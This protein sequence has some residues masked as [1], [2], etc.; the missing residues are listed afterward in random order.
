[1]ELVQEQ[2]FGQVACIFT[3]V[4]VSNSQQGIFA[5]IT[6]QHFG[7]VRLQKIVKPSGTRSFPGAHVQ[8]P[9]Q[10]MN[11]LKNSCGFRFECGF[12][13][14]ISTRIPNRRR[15]R[16]LMPVHPNILGVIHEGAPCT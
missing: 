8:T 9:A 1:M 6:N 12:H 10:T 15:D 13:H 3:V 11:K 14:Q 5:R 16:C 4:L 2:Q 7:N